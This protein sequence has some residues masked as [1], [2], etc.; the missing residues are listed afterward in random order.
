MK[1]SEGGRVIRQGIRWG[2][3]VWEG[4]RRG[5]ALGELTWP[6]L[7]HMEKDSDNRAGHPQGRAGGGPGTY[8]CADHAK[9]L[10][11]YSKCD[12]KL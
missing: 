2:G 10:R 9:D 7:R 8:G 1:G 6:C 5:V 4:G 11:S 3:G 12:G